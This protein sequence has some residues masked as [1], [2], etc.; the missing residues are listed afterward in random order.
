MMRDP[1]E[2]R[3]TPSRTWKTQANRCSGTQT[4]VPTTSPS[5]FALYS[6]ADCKRG[7]GVANQEGGAVRLRREGGPPQLTDSRDSSREGF[8][9][10]YRQNQWLNQSVSEAFSHH[11]IRSITYS[12]TTLSSSSTHADRKQPQRDSQRP[13]TCPQT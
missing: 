6:C 3:N 1:T 7:P 13:L 12:G 11:T 9:H 10:H 8:P 5:Q 4:T 2:V